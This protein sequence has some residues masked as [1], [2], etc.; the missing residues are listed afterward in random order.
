VKPALLVTFVLALSTASTLIVLGLRRQELHHGAS[1]GLRD[2]GV[3][4]NVVI[5][6]LLA[7]L[8]PWRGPCPERSASPLRSGR[9]SQPDRATR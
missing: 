6:G 2:L 8:V 5:F 9:S 4:L 7:L 1:K 3:L